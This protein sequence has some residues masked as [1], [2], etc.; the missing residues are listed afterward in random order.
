MCSFQECY[1]HNKT[2]ITT[3]AFNIGF[4]AIKYIAKYVEYPVNTTRKD[5][6]KRFKYNRI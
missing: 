1:I 2:L 4:A 6:R 5:K 3:V